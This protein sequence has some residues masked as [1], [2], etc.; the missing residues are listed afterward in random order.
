MSLVMV[1]SGHKIGRSELIS[2]IDAY[3]RTR[4]GATFD[5]DDFDCLSSKFVSKLVIRAN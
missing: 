4:S 3:L 5:R 1:G 2:L